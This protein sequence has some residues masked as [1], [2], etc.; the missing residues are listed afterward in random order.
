MNADRNSF[1]DFDLFRAS[2]EDTAADRRLRGALL[3]AARA[4]A[5]S[6]SALENAVLQQWHQAQEALDPALA[7]HAGRYGVPGRG[8]W[9]WPGAG[10]L[11]LA[12]L[13]LALWA[14]NRA[15]PALDELMQVDVLSRM[16]I[17][18]L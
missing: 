2:P 8:S 4:E 12:A 6:T 5:G 13:A 10:L 3:Q 14:A 9:R 7:G 16:A 17:D 1:D 15:D 11:V 18:E